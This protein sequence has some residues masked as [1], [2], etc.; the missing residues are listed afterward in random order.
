MPSGLEKTSRHLACSASARGSACSSP[1]SSPAA[2][3]PNRTPLPLRL[4]VGRLPARAARTRA[5][6]AVLAQP[7]SVSIF[8]RRPIRNRCD[9]ELRRSNA[10]RARRARPARDELVPAARGVAPHRGAE[11]RGR[12]VSPPHVVG[13]AERDA[14]PRPGNHEPSRRFEPRGPRRLS[15][16]SRTSSCS[17][18]RATVWST[19]PC[20]RTFQPRAARS[21]TSSSTCRERA[22]RSNPVVALPPVGTTGMPRTP[23]TGG[24]PRRRLLAARFLQARHIARKVGWHG[25]RPDFG[26][27][28]PPCLL[29]GR[30]CDAGVLGS[31]RDSRR[32]LRLPRRGRRTDAVPAEAPR[33]RRAAATQQSFVLLAAR[34]AARAR[35]QPA[36]QPLLRTRA[37]PG[38]NLRAR[39]TGQREARRKPTST[40]ND[41]APCAGTASRAHR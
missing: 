40:P 26:R 22:P 24:D 35:K 12:T 14:R 6:A 11:S 32:P 39:S 23:R 19:A 18:I 8:R 28:E 27:L 15:E 25:R 38:A 31:L 10:A 37:V 33:P 3:P 36:A 4:T 9:R 13:P 34:R 29:V 20:A 1:Q 17:W 16:H 2:P 5:A 7:K 30:S 21:P 41:D